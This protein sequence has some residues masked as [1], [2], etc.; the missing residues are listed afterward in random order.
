MIKCN[1]CDKLFAY[2][3]DFDRHK[4]RKNK[5]AILQGK[6]SIFECLK[7]NRTFATKAS[8]ERHVAK[9][10]DSV[11]VRVNDAAIDIP[12]EL[13]KHDDN[14]NIVQHNVTNDLNSLQCTYCIKEFSRSDS[15]KRHLESSCKAFQHSGIR[16]L[17]FT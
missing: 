17:E 15:L 2:F 8:L 13:I 16:S 10:C 14:K 12:P 4:N 9:A 5:C 11:I 3:S 1:R 6:A 7:C